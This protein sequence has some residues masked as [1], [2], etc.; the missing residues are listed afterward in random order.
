LIRERHGGK[1]W[2]TITENPGEKRSQD[3]NCH[4]NIVNSRLGGEITF[5]GV[6]VSRRMLACLRLKF[7]SESARI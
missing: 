5:K 7:V 1:R 2:N 4:V 6:M 3:A